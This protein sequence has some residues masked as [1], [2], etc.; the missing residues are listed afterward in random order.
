[1]DAFLKKFFPNVHTKLKEDTNTSNYCKFNSQLLTLFTSSLY[2]ASF[3][4]SFF[5]AKAT[6]SFGRRPSMFVGGAAY[7]AGAALSG[8][9]SSLYM[10]I[11]GRIL[12][13]VG[14]GFANQSVPLYLSE[15]APPTYRGAISNSF[16]FSL[17]MGALSAN[18][19]NYATVKMDGDWGWRISLTMAAFPA[20]ILTLG[21]LFLPETPN[22]II[23]RT[24]NHQ[25]AKIV[26]VED[27]VITKI[28]GP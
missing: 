26:G 28:E 22:S 21:S 2:V 11:S 6:R 25:K 5:A 4:T 15:M 23:Q 18:L 17:N 14:I 12:L 16:Q 20:V 7:L 3:T 1:M 24:E 8:T 19:I 13:G 27:E 9:A 10:L